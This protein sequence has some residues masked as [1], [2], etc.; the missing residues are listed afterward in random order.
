KVINRTA[1]LERLN[2]K[3][4]SEIHDK[5]EFIRAISHDLGAPLRN[6]N[7]ITSVLLLKKKEE[8]TDDTLSK[9]QRISANAKVQA[10]LINDLLE[11]SRIRSRPAKREN[12]D[13][14]ELLEQLRDSLTFDLEKSRISL[15]V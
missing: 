12:V 1:E 7:G 9:L 4:E 2:R 5:N 11:L 14:A 3:L 13:L 15:I 10:D 6:I 8:F